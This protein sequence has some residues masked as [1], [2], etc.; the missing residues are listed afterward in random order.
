MPS[1]LDDIRLFAEEQVTANSFKNFIKSLDVQGKI[2]SFQS[3]LQNLSMAFNVSRSWNTGCPT[4][5]GIFG[6]LPRMLP[7][8][9]SSMNFCRGSVQFHVSLPLHHHWFTTPVIS[10]PIATHPRS[11]NTEPKLSITNPCASPHLPANLPRSRSG[12]ES[13]S[14]PPATWTYVM[15]FTT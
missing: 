12:T 8:K 7:S 5:T 4:P 13:R 14:S 11:L 2:E 3:R 9:A 6:R 1:V 15:L 10:P